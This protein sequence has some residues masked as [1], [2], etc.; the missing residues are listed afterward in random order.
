MPTPQA[1]KRG[2][3]TASCGPDTLPQYRIPAGTHRFAYR[4]RPYR[5]GDEDPA[6]LAREDPW[7]RPGLHSK[8]R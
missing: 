3:G 6:I 2:L 1:R 7:P 4:L 5:I 8:R